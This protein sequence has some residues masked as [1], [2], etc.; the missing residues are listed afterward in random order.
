MSRITYKSEEEVRDVAEKLRQHRIPTDVIHLDTGWFETDWRSNYQFSKTRFKDPA[1]MIGD[2]RDLSVHIG[3]GVLQQLLAKV[4]E[5]ALET[6]LPAVGPVP[7]LRRD[8]VEE[9]VGGLGGAFRVAMGVDE[10]ALV[11]TEDELTLKV[12]FGFARHELDGRGV[13]QLEG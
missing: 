1:K 2:L 10:L 3:E 8:Q 7:I 11:V 9:M 6:Q 4:A 13:K 5:R 12:R